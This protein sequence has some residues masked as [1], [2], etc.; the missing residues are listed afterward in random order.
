MTAKTKRR[1]SPSPVL[2]GLPAARG[3]TAKTKKSLS[4]LPAVRPADPETT[5]TK[6]PRENPKSKNVSPGYNAL[7]YAG[8]IT[9][10]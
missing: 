7:H 5:G 6:V 10:K 1:I 8:D 2:A 4:R 9:F 3:M